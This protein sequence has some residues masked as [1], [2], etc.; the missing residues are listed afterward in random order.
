M[1]DQLI[2]LEGSAA[3]C[4]GCV[5]RNR[6]RPRMFSSFGVVEKGVGVAF[7]IK[8]SFTNMFRIARC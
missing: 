4:G 5:F 1:L 2:T 3:G 6:H 8:S 7:T